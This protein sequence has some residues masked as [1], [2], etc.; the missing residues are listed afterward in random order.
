MHYVEAY[1][2]LTTHMPLA[3]SR[4]PE[5]VPNR[6]PVCRSEVSVEPSLFF[7]DAPCP[8]CGTLLWFIQFAGDTQFFDHA[9]SAALRARIL[10]IM[11]ANRGVSVSD[12]LADPQT[13]KDLDVDSLEIVELVMEVEE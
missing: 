1:A 2:A 13:L 3:S 9:E 4:T 11:A 7:G 12:L 10:E 5:G 6:C 8:G